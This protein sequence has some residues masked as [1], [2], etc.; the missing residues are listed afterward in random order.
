MLLSDLSQ[1]Y[2]SGQ[3]TGKQATSDMGRKESVVKI[4][5]T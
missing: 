2:Q 1:Q 4:L 3:S 5:R